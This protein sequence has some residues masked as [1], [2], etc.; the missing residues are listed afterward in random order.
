MW[1]QRHKAYLKEHRKTSYTTMLM[2]DKVN[3]F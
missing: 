1:E 3:S 2:E